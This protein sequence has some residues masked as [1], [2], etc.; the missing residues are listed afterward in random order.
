MERWREISVRD[1]DA[2]NDEMTMT[3]RRFA[4]ARQSSPR[5]PSSSRLS[6]A[7]ARS[8]SASASARRTD[9]SSKPIAVN[10]ST[11]AGVG[12][13]AARKS[14][15]PP[16][17]NPPAPWRLPPWRARGPPWLD[18]ATNTLGAPVRSRPGSSH[19]NV[20]AKNARTSDGHQRRRENATRAFVRLAVRA[21]R[22]AGLSPR[23]SQTR[24]SMF[25]GNHGER[26]RSEPTTPSVAGT[27]RDHRTDR[28]DSAPVSPSNGGV[29]P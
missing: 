11:A 28:T 1:D 20:A 16:R 9:P 14:P 8:F 2:M 24:A 17:S 25:S 12:G 27:K 3:I 21:R 26:R 18:P 22:D 19:P 10:A 6:V 7:T 23:P 15:G 5:S 4:N 13:A 29:A